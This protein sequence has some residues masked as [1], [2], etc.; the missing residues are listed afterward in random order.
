MLGGGGDDAARIVS[1]PIGDELILM[2]V[3]WLSFT[4]GY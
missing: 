3:G 2:V 1:Y 4:I